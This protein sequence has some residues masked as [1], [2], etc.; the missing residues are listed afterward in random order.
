MSCMCV[1]VMWV[2]ACVHVYRCMCVNIMWVWACVYVCKGPFPNDVIVLR[3]GGSL[4]IMTADD[5]G[6][7]GVWL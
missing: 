1:N 2:W 6:E 7:G 4:Q 3:A 5:G